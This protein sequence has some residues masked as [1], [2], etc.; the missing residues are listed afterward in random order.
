MAGLVTDFFCAD[1]ELFVG[2]RTIRETGVGPPVFVPVAG[3]GDIGI[4]E[5]EIALSF[6]IVG[7]LVPQIDLFAVA[8]FDFLVDIGHVNSLL[9]VGSGGREK[10]EEVVALLGGGLGSGLC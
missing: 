1:A 3:I 6:W 8:L 4:G 10:H 5:S 7:G 9:F 2:V